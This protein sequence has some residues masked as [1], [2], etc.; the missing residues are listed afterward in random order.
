MARRIT[1]ERAP[2]HIIFTG[3]C[4]FEKSA[5]GYKDI[6]TGLYEWGRASPGNNPRVDPLQLGR[7]PAIDN[8][9]KSN[10]GMLFCTGL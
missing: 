4:D 8:T 7:G 2:L 9:K 6:S 5:C 3:N 10:Q 1:L